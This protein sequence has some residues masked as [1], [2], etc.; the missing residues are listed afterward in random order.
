MPKKM[1]LC[2]T[3]MLSSTLML[4]SL[5]SYAAWDFRG[6][7]NN[8]NATRMSFVGADRHFI[9]QSFTENQDEFKIAKDGGWAV[10]FPV[11]NFQ[12]APARTYDIFFLENKKT[13]QVD[14]VLANESWV[15]RGT[16]N[17]WGV[18]PLIQQD[19]VFKTCQD[20]DASN[21]A[22]KISNGNKAE[23]AES[24]PEQNFRV[25][26]NAS[27]DITFNPSTRT[28]QAIPRN[29]A[30]GGD[31]T[32]L[33]IHRSLIV[34]DMATLDAADFSFSSVIEQLT[35][36]INAQNSSAKT[37]A[38]ELFARFWDTQNPAPGFVTGG[39]KCESFLN[40]FPNDCRANQEGVQ[41]QFPQDFMTNYRPIALINRFDL[42]DTVNFNDCG[43]YRVIFALTNSS[44]GR[45]F[46]IFES[47]LPNPV[48]GSANGCA[49]IVELWKDLS[50]QENPAVRANILR[51]FYFNGIPSQNVKPVIDINNY[52]VATGQI[53]TN[54]FMNGGPWVLKEFKISIENGLGFIKPVSVKANPFGSLFADVNADNRA[55]DFRNQFLTNLNTVL[56]GDLS[57]FSLT[58]QEDSHN[59]GRSHASGVETFEN[60][61]RAHVATGSG[62]FRHAIEARTA[63]LGSHL[64]ADQVLNRAT[65]MTCGGCHNPGSF[66]LTSPNSVA[67]GQSWPDTLGF[68]HVNEF[69]FNGI[70]A[71]S[72]ALENVFLPSRK[73]GMQAFIGALAA[74]APGITASKAAPRT[75]L[76]KPLSTP[77]RS[78]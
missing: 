64:T 45:N 20:F 27:V 40:G 6:E 7:P 38:I 44:S 76:R 11:K 24:Y 54:Q 58:V 50:A 49:P 31:L 1:F 21:P 68:T 33:D 34:H 46:I 52:A 66:G 47:Q 3:L 70:F 9:R 4:V 63:E 72:P 37:D 48:P 75:I 25:P 12:L 19:D 5:N 35:N 51:E 28:I 55:V 23:W 42:R 41:A 32:S 2:S 15:F 26:N 57:T 71:L 65:A 18:T 10:S 60:D 53:R 77:K 61:F 17:S 29:A 74:S 73:F 36:Q 69:A 39:P 43:E 30:C 22:F 16:P 59:N 14:E 8:W 56:V 78:G 13:I 67:N 62:A